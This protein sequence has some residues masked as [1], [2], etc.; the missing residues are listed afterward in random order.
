VTEGTPGDTQLG[1]Y[2]VEVD[3]MLSADKVLVNIANRCRKDAPFTIAES[4]LVT[5]EEAI[6]TVIG[7][8]EAR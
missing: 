7:V 3:I 4:R 1:T 6:G 8:L 5:R 2:L